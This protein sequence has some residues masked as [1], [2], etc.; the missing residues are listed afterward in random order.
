MIERDT[1][2]EK[3]SKLTRR[4]AIATVVGGA[5]IVTAMARTQVKSGRTDPLAAFRHSFQSP[6]F[7]LQ[8]GDD[9]A[10]AAEVGTV[11]QTRSG[12]RL[13]ITGVETFASYGRRQR[14]L[15]RPRAF[16]VNFELVGGRPIAGDT[17]H[18]LAH[19][20]HGVFDLFLITT[21]Q[22]PAFAQAVFN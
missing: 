2:A 20:R 9:T 11:L 12:A 6:F 3:R 18:T 10:W 15:I 21:P 4:A 8:R 22:L 19:P 7:S 16:A 17:I 5:T 1:M 13:R 14:N